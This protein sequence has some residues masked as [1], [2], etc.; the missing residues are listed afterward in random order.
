MLKNPI[1][2]LPEIISVLIFSGAIKIF[3]SITK[4]NYLIAL[5]QTPETSDI[6]LEAIRENAAKFFSLIILFAVTLF[7]VRVIVIS[8]EF[9]FI[10]NITLNKKIKVAEIPS[11]IKNLFVNIILLKI[12]TLFFFILI[13]LTSLT[14]RALLI[15]IIPKEAA[16]VLTIIL[17]LILVLFIILT[18]FFRYPA[19]ILEKKMNPK[20]GI[21]RS[22]NFF[23]KNKPLVIKAFLLVFLTG[24]TGRILALLIT[25]PLQN[26]P[27]LPAIINALLF[28]AL[29]LW[30]TLFLFNIYKKNYK[31]SL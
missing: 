3:L 29:S 26:I 20:T 13:A 19:C 21:A 10:K 23:N 16:V 1:L 28:I 8:I 31:V 24:A 5:L 18:L 4:L 11:H 25:K 30:S 22:I 7:I 12:Y 14:C 6:F 9:G 27:F 15:I 17:S 2:W